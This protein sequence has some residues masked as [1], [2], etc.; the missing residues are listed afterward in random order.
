MNHPW[1][2]RVW[3]VQ[4]SVLARDLVFLYSCRGLPLSLLHAAVTNFLHHCST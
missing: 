4:E 1:W 3:T 2:T